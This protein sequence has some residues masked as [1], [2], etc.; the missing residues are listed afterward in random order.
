MRL[1]RSALT[2]IVVACP[3]PLQRY[4]V[5]LEEAKAAAR[6]GLAQ[7]FRGLVEEG[8]AKLERDLREK[9]QEISRL[10]RGVRHM[11]SWR[12]GQSAM[13]ATLFDYLTSQTAVFPSVYH[14]YSKPMQQ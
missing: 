2:V 5:V 9:K 12:L 14:A 10:V 1:V 13:D 6:L 8:V 3:P 11:L 4:N 7:R